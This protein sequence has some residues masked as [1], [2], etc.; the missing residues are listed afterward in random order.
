MQIL[1]QLIILESYLE[2]PMQ[3]LFGYD[4]CSYYR[5]FIGGLICYPK[6]KLHRS[7]QVTNRT[8]DHLLKAS[9]ALSC[10]AG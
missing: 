10:G 6:K 8:S 5:G 2:T 9:Q 1:H 7:L 4:L 3:F